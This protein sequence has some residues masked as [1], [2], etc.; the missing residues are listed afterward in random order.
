[1]H[2]GNI[3]EMAAKF[4]AA[5]LALKEKKDVERL[6]AIIKPLIL[7]AKADGITDKELL[8][9]IN[10]VGLR[11]KFYPAKLKELRTKLLKPDQ[12]MLLVDGDND[13]LDEDLPAG[14][15]SAALNG[16]TS[17]GLPQ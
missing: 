4:T 16:H 14:V 17:S 10:N 5:Y 12:E 9:I 6:L 11:E 13:T 1:M 15:F 8:E 3:N 7:S 2:Q